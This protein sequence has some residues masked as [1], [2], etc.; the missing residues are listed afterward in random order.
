[1][2]LPE[3]LF[4][5]VPLSTINNNISIYSTPDTVF[6]FMVNP[7]TSSA[8]VPTSNTITNS[9]PSSS[10]TISGSVNNTYSV[11]KITL[12]VSNVQLIL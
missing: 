6:Y 10:S 12:P 3:A 1:M 5:G 11:S 9:V 4:N 2:I 7:S 8:F